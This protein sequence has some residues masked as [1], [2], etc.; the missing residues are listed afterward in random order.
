[1]GYR[2][3]RTETD[4]RSNCKKECTHARGQN[5]GNGP[6]EDDEECWGVQLNYC[7]TFDE[8]THPICTD[9]DKANTV[10][11]CG[12]DE[13]SA[14]GHCGNTC[15]TD[16]ECP[17][18]ELCFDVMEN[19]CDCHLE[20]LDSAGDMPLPNATGDVNDAFFEKDPDDMPL[21]NATGDVNDTFFEKDPEDMPL[22]NATG[23]V[24]DAFFEKD[25]EPIYNQEA[26]KD[27]SVSSGDQGAATDTDDELS[28]LG[29]NPFSLAKAK[30]QPYFV[31]SVGEGSVEG[32]ARD[33]ASFQVNLS[34][35]VMT[36]VSL[37][38]LFS[39]LM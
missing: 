38:A 34:V 36:I 11:R 13:A 21:P 17:G 28:M 20:L 1:M 39:Y 12:L 37:N 8:G 23:D 7:N 15:D 2:C 24:N 22:P 33:N 19:L 26:P 29:D 4:A 31:R 14:R 30:I 35:A 10:S 3:G 32:L 5:N 27:G 16:D 18:I 9:L 25:P 6:C